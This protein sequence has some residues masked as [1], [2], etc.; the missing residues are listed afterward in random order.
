MRII[1]SKSYATTIVV[2]GT[3]LAAMLIEMNNEVKSLWVQ[4]TTEGKINDYFAYG[5][6]VEMFEVDPELIE[7]DKRIYAFSDSWR[8]YDGD[9]DK[10]LLIVGGYPVTGCE[11]C[12]FYLECIREENF[13]PI[14][15]RGGYNQICKVS[16]YFYRGIHGV[17][18]IAKWKIDNNM[19]TERVVSVMNES[20]KRRIK[21]DGKELLYSVGGILINTEGIKKKNKMYD[22]EKVRELKERIKERKLIEK[23]KKLRGD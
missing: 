14:N 22:P 8:G 20:K 15:L 2:R 23:L 10:G 16:K 17:E 13:K 7:D 3:E 1:C 18:K 19:L 6:K 11:D 5:H 9:F 4:T 21:I 12:P